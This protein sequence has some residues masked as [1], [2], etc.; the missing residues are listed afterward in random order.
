M[1]PREQ[2]GSGSGAVR[3]QLRQP[4]FLAYLI[5][6]FSIGV[7]WIAHYGITR[8]LRGVDE[9]SL[10]LNLLFLFFVAFLRARSGTDRGSG[11]GVPDRT[12]CAG[13][14]DGSGL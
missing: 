11:D 4:S 6:F 12:R 2:A 9:I 5:S 8:L 10:R 7:R 1:S 3:E 14:P 13:L